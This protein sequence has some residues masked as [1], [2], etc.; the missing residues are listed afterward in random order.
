MKVDNKEKK[1]N[2]MTTRKIDINAI[3]R[4]IANH[5]DDYPVINVRYENHD[6]AV[7]DILN[8]SKAIFDSR[9]FPDYDS[10]EY[11]ELEELD[12]TSTYQLWDGD[13]EVYMADIEK[14]ITEN[15]L[16]EY[17]NL[18]TGNPIGMGLDDGEQILEDCEVIFKIF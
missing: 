13:R 2:E 15:T 18:V 1:E 3:K 14:V 6:F 9:E 11:N 7:G 4:F 12:G 5:A 8:P 16:F 17:C 10:D